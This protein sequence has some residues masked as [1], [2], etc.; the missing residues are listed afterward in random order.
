MSGGF[1]AIPQTDPRAGYLAQRAEIDAALRRVAESGWY[2]LGPEVEAFEKEFAAYLGVSHAVGV[3]SGTDALELALRGCGVGPGQAVFTVSHTAVATVV[4]IERCGAEAVLIDINPESYTLDPDALDGVLRQWQG[5]TCPA[6]I[7]PVHLYGQPAAM[8]AL[9][10]IAQHYGLRVIEDCAQAHGAR[11]DGRMAGTWGDAAAFSFYPTKNLG[12][13]GDAGAVVTADPSI[14]ERVRELRQYGW[15]K[16]YISATSGINSR[17]DAV[18]AAVLRVKLRVLDAGN[19]RRRTIAGIYHKSLDELTAN[20]RLPT[21]RKGVE[22]VYHQFV[23]RS[24]ARDRLQGELRNAGIGTLIHYPEPVHRQPAYAH[25][26]MHSDL[27]HSEQAAAHVLSLP[28]YPELEDN[29]VARVAET[30]HDLLRD[31]TR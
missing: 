18:Q 4:A 7:L 17:L 16:R 15:R 30:L 20:L 5:I 14:A 6:A 28:M 8:P 12:A 29:Q 3:A 24:T 19:A 9:L 23:I 31:D 26:L 22:H 11:L 2:V 13:F 25:R 1:L 27:F 21:C 10:K